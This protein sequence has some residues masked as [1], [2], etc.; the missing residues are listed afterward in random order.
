MLFG[1]SLLT[2]FLIACFLLLSTFIYWIN[3]RQDYFKNLNV[4]FV[5]STPLLGVFK[6]A[7]LGKIGIYDHVAAI[8]NRPD[9]KDK[10]FF[11]MFLFHKPSL[12]INDPELIKKILVKDFAS[13]ANRYSGSD[14]HDPLGN[15][16]LFSIKMPLWKNMRGKLS[17]FF[18]SGKLKM[19]YYLLDK[20]SDDMIKHVN[21]RLDQDGKVELEMKELAS[22]YSTDVIA[23]CAYG[24]EANCLENPNSEFRKAGAAMF[25]PTLKRKIEFPVFFMLPQLMKLFNFTLFSSATTKFIQE[26]VPSVMNDREKR[27]AKR[28]DLIDT[29]L[30]L[31]HI[32]IANDDPELSMDMLMAQAAVFFAAGKLKILWD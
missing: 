19:M 9:V 31:K 1:L 14:V 11:G 3:R 13:F 23:S 27:G 32:G 20:I 22:L 5:P 8:Y 25:A 2:N 18:S 21:K 10:P 4:P 7:V 12:M 16:N 15:N 26:M 28:N 29:L 30:D 6:E 17:P 24:V